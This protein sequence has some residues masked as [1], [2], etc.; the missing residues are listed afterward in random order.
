MLI[1]TLPF[2][3]RLDWSQLEGNFAEFMLLILLS[4]MHKIFY[5]VILGDYGWK[6]LGR[7]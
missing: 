4:A 3:I 2:H 6:Y 1:D 5:K 7:S